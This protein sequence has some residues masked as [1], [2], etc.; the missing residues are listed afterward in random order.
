MFLQI[1]VTDYP[2]LKKTGDKENPLVPTGKFIPRFHSNYKD[3]YE[4]GTKG[5]LLGRKAN[6]NEAQRILRLTELEGKIK[7]L[8]DEYYSI[9][10][11]L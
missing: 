5:D 10:N 11:S 3:L 2:E 4:D 6:K 9:I 1:L 7:V 8:V